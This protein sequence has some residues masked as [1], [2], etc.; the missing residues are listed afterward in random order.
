[1]TGWSKTPGYDIEGL[2]ALNG[3]VKAVGLRL[4]PPSGGVLAVDFDSPDA[5]DK[6]R[7]V[8]NREPLDLPHRWRHLRQGDARAAPIHR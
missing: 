4:G 1:M 2:N 3:V 5:V 6:F 8:F 7:D